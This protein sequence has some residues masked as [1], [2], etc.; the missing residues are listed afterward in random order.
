MNCKYFGVRTSVRE[1]SKKCQECKESFPEV[2]RKCTLETNI[3]I[4]TSI[5][6]DEKGNTV[7]IPPTGKVSDTELIIER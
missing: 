5:D 6:V 2:F 7:V 1:G 4:S 3:L